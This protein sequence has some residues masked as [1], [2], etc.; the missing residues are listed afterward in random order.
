MWSSLCDCISLF[1]LVPFSSSCQTVQAQ[2]YIAW[3][4]CSRR[5]HP[6]ESKEKALACF[7]K[8]A[9]CGL[10]VNK[11]ATSVKV[12]AM[13]QVWEGLPDWRVFEYSVAGFAETMLLSAHRHASAVAAAPHGKRQW[14]E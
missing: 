1:W 4:V 3:Q 7:A 10:T 5:G 14:H 9:T 2:Q 11:E 8:C 12:I 13:W 6:C